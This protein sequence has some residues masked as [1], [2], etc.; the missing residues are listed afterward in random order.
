MEA[1]E[2]LLGQRVVFSVDEE[3]YPNIDNKYNLSIKE[4]LEG[5][6]T[7]EVRERTGTTKTEKVFYS[8]I[9]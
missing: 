7:V 5:R 9:Y 3:I 1:K 4:R 8:T 2:I 6:W